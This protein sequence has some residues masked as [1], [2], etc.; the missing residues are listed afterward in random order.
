[1]IGAIRCLLLWLPVAASLGAATPASAFLVQSTQ[2]GNGPVVMAS[3]GEDDVP[4]RI[5]AAGSADLGAAQTAAILRQSFTVWENVEG[6]RLRFIDEGL[7]SGRDAS[8]RDRRN[9]LIF[10]ETGATL[11]APDG[12]GIIAV[13]RINSDA[14]TGEIF[15][16]DIIF[17]GRDFRFAAEPTPGRILLRDV[18]VHEIGHFVGLDHTPLAGDPVQRPTMNPFYFGDGPGEASSLAADDITG[19]R[20]LYPTFAFSSMLGA[21]TGRIE[22]PGGRGV[23]GAH[24][25]ALDLDS[26]ELYSTLSGAETGVRDRGAYALRGLP[27]GLYRVAIEPVSGGLD[28]SNFSSLFAT[29]DADFP[30][31]YFGN[32][33]IPSTALPVLVTGGIGSSNI[34]F[35]TGFIT[36][37]VPFVRSVDGPGNTPDAIGPYT[38]FFDVVNAIR[39]EV[40]IEIDGQ[41]SAITAEALGGGMFRSQIPGQHVGTHVRYRLTA[42]SATGISVDFP[43]GGRWLEFDVIGLSGAPL[44]FTVL[45]DAG[46]LGVFDTGAD[47]EVARVDLGDDPIQ[48]LH[49]PDGQF[50]YVSNL[51]SSEITVIETATFRIADRI[52]VAAQ[53]LDMALSP[54]GGTLY[55]TNSGASLLTAINLESR[56]VLSSV[57]VGA[58]VE[59]PYGIATSGRRVY[60]TDLRSNAVVAVED[61]QVIARIPVG[62]GPRSLATDADG[63]HLYVTSINGRDLTIIDT[64]RNSIEAAI[65]L[66]VSGAF[67]VAIGPQDE[68]AYVTAHTEGVVVVIDLDSRQVI[69]TIQVGANPRGLTFSPTGDQLFVTTAESD[70]IYIFDSVTRQSLGTFAAAGGPRGI[71]VVEAPAAQVTAV[72][73]ADATPMA[74][75]LSQLYPNPFNPETNLS[76]DLPAAGEVTFEVYDALGQRLRRIELPAR[77]AGH[78]ELSWDGRDDDALAV[79]SGVYLFVVRWDSPTSPVLKIRKGVLLR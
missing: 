2:S 22:E 71:S 69:D 8:R 26:G 23:F 63:S 17:N 37:G 40:I 44:A 58:L 49:S 29:L 36:P 28:A 68:F 16:A 41:V 48:I 30:L 24:V 1:M 47:V 57:S 6:S 9:L 35:T 76:L 27:T 74:Y 13:T 38:T 66:P 72:D 10:D 67:A 45:R 39:V 12:S 61:G 65:P 70:E 11:G 14:Q 5:D 77:S 53:P 15:D 20:V 4:F 51:E 7:S 19:L 18:A 78:H 34:D 79:A 46:V 64:E 62:G 32:T 52:S 21:I 60:V 42:A 73:N 43:A 3:W 31:E 59:G 50:L 55:V 54:D 33:D 56:R 75:A 25:T